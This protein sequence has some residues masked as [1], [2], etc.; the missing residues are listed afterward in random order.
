MA[1]PENAEDLDR[2]I[3]AIVIL[4]SSPIV[5]LVANWCV[6][7]CNPP[8]PVHVV[9][10]EDEVIGARMYTGPMCAPSPR[11]TR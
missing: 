8:N 10:S 2:F 6:R 5:R 4:V 9:T 1:Q 3:E 7:A 11:T